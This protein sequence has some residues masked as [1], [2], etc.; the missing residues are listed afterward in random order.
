[1]IVNSRL[2]YA[3]DIAY[4]TL[5]YKYNIKI[6]IAYGLTFLCH[7]FAIALSL[8]HPFFDYST[9]VTVT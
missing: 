4:N 8:L 5:F 6:D 3:K 2:Y 7:M 9:V 1:M